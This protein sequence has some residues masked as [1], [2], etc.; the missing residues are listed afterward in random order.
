M[1]GIHNLPFH[2]GVDLPSPPI[3]TAFD[4][5]ISV[6]EQVLWLH[7]EVEDMRNELTEKGYLDPVESDEE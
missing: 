6:E 7:K 1:R 5:G 2:R 3:P 4:P